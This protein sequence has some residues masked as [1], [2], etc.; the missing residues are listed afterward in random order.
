MLG[1]ASLPLLAHCD[2]I[3]TAFELRPCRYVTRAYVVPM[4][5]SARSGRV[6]LLLVVRSGRLVRGPRRAR[7]RGESGSPAVAAA[8]HAVHAP[9]GNFVGRRW[10]GSFRTTV[11]SRMKRGVRRAD[12]R[13]NTCE[14]TQSDEVR[15]V[16]GRAW[17]DPIRQG[18]AQ[19][20]AQ[21]RRRQR[22]A[23]RWCQR[24]PRPLIR[25]RRSPVIAAV[26][27]HGRYQPA[28]DRRLRHSPGSGLQRIPG[29][30]QERGRDAFA[31]RGWY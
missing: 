23:R 17:W 11:L 26:R 15:S 13:G 9:D 22:R 16:R 3:A 21:R 7:S 18:L 4:H 12:R 19:R 20:M 6:A 30:E 25:D 1:V 14:S 29:P 2:T 27:E 8:F 28:R 10:A 24:R 5:G 31:L